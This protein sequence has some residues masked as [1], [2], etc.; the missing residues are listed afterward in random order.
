MPGGG[1]ALV[2]PKT[3]VSHWAAAEVRRVV[4][5]HKVVRAAGAGQR[6]QETGGL[7]LLALPLVIG[8]QLKHLLLRRQH[9]L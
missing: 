1:G 9:P 3:L 7:T 6:R 8:N 4:Q 5:T 2:S